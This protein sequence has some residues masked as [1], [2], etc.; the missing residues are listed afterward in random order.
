MVHHAVLWNALLGCTIDADHGRVHV[1]HC[2]RN[3]R[4]EMDGVGVVCLL[5]GMRDVSFPLTG[6]CSWIRVFAAPPTPPNQPAA[7]AMMKAC[8]VNGGDAFQILASI[9]YAWLT[10]PALRG[11]PPPPV[12]GSVPSPVTG[13]LEVHSVRRTPLR[14][15]NACR[16]S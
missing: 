14:S 16:F 8:V 11:A 3:M 7:C 13:F 2:D 6:T 12:A 4:V 9:R 1:T 5:R 15:T 10:V